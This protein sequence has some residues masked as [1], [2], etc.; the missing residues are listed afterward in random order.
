M[1]DNLI[2]NV[3]CVIHTKQSSA[4]LADLIDPARG[5]TSVRALVCDVCCMMYAAAGPRTT[6]R[7]FKAAV[8][9]HA[10]D[11]H[12]KLQVSGCV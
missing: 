4:V 10:F 11:N 2:V 1:E 12:K 6:F 8:S 9:A 7:N 5:H 3:C